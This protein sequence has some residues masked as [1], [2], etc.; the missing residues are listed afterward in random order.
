MEDNGSI[1]EY[2]G[3]KNKLRK[4]ATGNERQESYSDYNI[5]LA[6]E[7]SNILENRR[8]KSEIVNEQMQQK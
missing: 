1:E 5:K 8:M 6:R 2:T 4:Q 3:R 7:Y